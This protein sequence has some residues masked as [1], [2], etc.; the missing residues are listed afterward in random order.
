MTELSL[1]TLQ[2]GKEGR[3]VGPRSQVKA[4]VAELPEVTIEKHRRHMGLQV[5]GKRFAWYLEDHHGDGRIV[6]T[7]KTALGVNQTLATSRPDRYFLPS[8]VAGRGW[9]GYWLDVP[10][11]DWDEVAELLVDAYRLTAPKRLI[12][13]LDQRA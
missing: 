3:L 1:C 5:R 13:V 10:A 12:T 9:I 6:L 8:Y 2:A 4:I 11:T 7:C